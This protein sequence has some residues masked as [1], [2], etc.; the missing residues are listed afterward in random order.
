MPPVST[1]PVPLGGI[2]SPL[3]SQVLTLEDL[4]LLPTSLAAA[5]PLPSSNCGPRTPH[6]SWPADCPHFE[7]RHH[8]GFIIM[9]KHLSDQT[10]AV[11]SRGTCGAHSAILNSL[12]SGTMGLRGCTANAL[13]WAPA[14]GPPGCHLL[15][16]L[17]AQATPHTF[18][19]R[20]SQSQ[21]SLLRSP[22]HSTSC[23]TC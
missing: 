19:C 3:E 5:P 20:R 18:P 4:G 14:T 12:P 15:P 7:S 11:P 9:F 21:R 8:Y 23:C 22:R 16:L 13:L 17:R 10:L 2:A 6:P 1:G